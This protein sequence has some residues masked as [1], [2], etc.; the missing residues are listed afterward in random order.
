VIVPDVRYLSFPYFISVVGIYFLWHHVMR[1]K[2]KRNVF[3][4]FR[5]GNVKISLSG[6][7]RRTTVFQWKVRTTWRWP[8]MMNSSPAGHRALTPTGIDPF[9]ILS[10]TLL[11]LY[12]WNIRLGE[13]WLVRWLLR[14]P[15]STGMSSCAGRAAECPLD[16][17]HCGW[18]Q[19]PCIGCMQPCT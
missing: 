19:L 17:R 4:L 11:F 10:G 5:E 3:I 7:R 18:R 16:L 1:K 2:Q 13:W 14:R 8:C 12:A 6:I 9:G 15:C